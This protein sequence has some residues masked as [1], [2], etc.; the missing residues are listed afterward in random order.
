MPTPD[1]LLTCKELAAVLRKHVSYVYAMRRQGFRMPAGV[2]SVAMA[3]RFLGRVPNPRG[4]TGAK[5]VERARS[6]R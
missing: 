3:F 4:R 5:A 1:H 2:A 6:T